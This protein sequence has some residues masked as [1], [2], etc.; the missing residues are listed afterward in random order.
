MLNFIQF[1]RNHLN[2]KNNNNYNNNN[3]K[4]SSKILKVNLIS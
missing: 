1:N 2:K 3:N 4:V